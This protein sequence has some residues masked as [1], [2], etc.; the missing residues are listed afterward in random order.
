MDIKNV[1]LLV[2]ISFWIPQDMTQN[3]IL[4]RIIRLTIDTAH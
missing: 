3:H 2:I 4:Y 1:Y